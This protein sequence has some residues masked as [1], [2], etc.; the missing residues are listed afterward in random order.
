VDYWSI[1]KDSATLTMAHRDDPLAGQISIPD[2]APAEAA[3]RFKR[4]SARL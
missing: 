4:A 1:S 3:E 2:K